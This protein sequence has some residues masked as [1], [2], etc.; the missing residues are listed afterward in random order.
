MANFGTHISSSILVGGAYGAVGHL[1]LDMPLPSAAMAAGIC[2]LGG[3]LPDID[4]DHGVI[5]RESLGLVAA[6]APLL[7]LDRLA[8][9]ELPRETT[10]LILAGLYLVIRFGL[11]AVLRTWTIHR[12]MWHSIPAALTAGALV[13]YLC[14]CPATEMRVYKAGAIVLGY[15]WHL[16]LDEIYAVDARRVRLKKSFGT[17]LKMWGNKPLAN[18]MAYG[19]LV[20]MLW[21][22][23]QDPSPP[24]EIAPTDPIGNPQHATR[25]LPPS[26]FQFR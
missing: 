25:P 6:V 20:G 24:R 9:Y 8:P 21:I 11:G 14:A 3:I 18:M 15:L 26:P 4:S 13:Y 12:G 10:V 7:T 1:S 19:L 5:L 16:V 17:A 22:N 2:T 23:M